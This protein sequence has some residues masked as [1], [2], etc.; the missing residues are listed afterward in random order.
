MGKVN[1]ISVSGEDIQ[2]PAECKVILKW[3]VQ[4]E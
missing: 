4:Y 1:N 2:M 3:E